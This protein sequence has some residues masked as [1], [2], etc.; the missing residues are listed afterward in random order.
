MLLFWR[1][2]TG[3]KLSKLFLNVF[4]LVAIKYQLAVKQPYL[5]FFC[6]SVWLSGDPFSKYIK[7]NYY[8]VQIYTFCGLGFVM[9]PCGDVSHWILV[10]E[11]SCLC[12]K[13][14]VLIIF[15]LVIMWKNT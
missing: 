3:Q 7:S 9:N 15:C 6:N 5:L 10:K 1:N 12:H 11:A 2:Q 4:K 13:W 8:L 14:T